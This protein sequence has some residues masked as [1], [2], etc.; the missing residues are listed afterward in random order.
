MRRVRLAGLLGV[1][2]G[3]ARSLQGQAVD[4]LPTKRWGLEATLVAGA[5]AWS[6][7]VLASRLSSIPAGGFG[8]RLTHWHSSRWRGL[9]VLDRADRGA[10]GP[11]WR[12]RT[13]Y[14][15][16]GALVA[17]ELF[18][19]GPLALSLGGGLIIAWP[20]AGLGIAP[21]PIY[22]RQSIDLSA[23]EYSARLALE[24]RVGHRVP[25]AGRV[26]FQRGLN[27][28][29]HSNP[30]VADGR[31]DHTTPPYNKLLAFELGATLLRW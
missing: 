24:A 26:T 29:L 18:P 15:E 31:W 22:Y 12:F 19:V 16:T 30:A 8:V 21:G 2:L 14:I 6:Q 3:G 10:N 4:T 17:R 27:R 11:G 1:A 7:P 23:R 25:L 9:V 28:I 5:S 13:R 20:R